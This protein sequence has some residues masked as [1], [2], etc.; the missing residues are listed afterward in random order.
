MELL[1]NMSDKN[2]NADFQIVTSKRSKFKGNKKLN[3]LNITE[4]TD[5]DSGLNTEEFLR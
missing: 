4:T 5:T 2:K 3:N 1:Y